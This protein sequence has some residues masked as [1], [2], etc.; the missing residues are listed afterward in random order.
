MS[1]KSERSKTFTGYV[2]LNWKT[3]GMK[4]MIRKPT[5]PTPFEVPVEINIKVN[6][7]EFKVLKADGEITLSEHKIN[8]MTVHSI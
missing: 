5:R 7:P 8:E 6:I 2:M 1:E 4:L 3:G